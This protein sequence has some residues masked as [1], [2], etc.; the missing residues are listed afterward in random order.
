MALYS[1]AIELRY[2]SPSA[3]LVHETDHVLC[4]RK[5]EL[6]TKR[7]EIEFKPKFATTRLIYVTS[8]SGSRMP[9]RSSLNQ[10]HYFINL[11]VTRYPRHTTFSR[12]TR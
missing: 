4:D 6:A 10:V 7:D 3:W 9:P 11:L 1:V 12:K 5:F 8:R 2:P